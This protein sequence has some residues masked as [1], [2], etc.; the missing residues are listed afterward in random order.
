M[1]IIC[2]LGGSFERRC[3]QF[4]STIFIVDRASAG[5]RYRSGNI[6]RSRGTAAIRQCCARLLAMGTPEG[7][8]PRAALHALGSTKAA[9]SGS[10]LMPPGLRQAGN[11]HGDAARL[12]ISVRT[13]ATRQ[14]R[15]PGYR[16]RREL[17]HWHPARRSRPVSFQHARARRG[18]VSSFAHLAL[19]GH[20]QRQCVQPDGLRNR[21]RALT[22]PGPG[23]SLPDVI[24]HHSKSMLP[25]YL[26]L[27]SR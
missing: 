26:Y 7:P 6:G 16:R 14:S 17:A 3:G 21:R 12:V 23:C 10:F 19:S 27:V 24:A 15:S 1:R 9:R 13:P 11:V 8:E 18:D 25:L 5:G 4:R 20:R 22:P 2:P